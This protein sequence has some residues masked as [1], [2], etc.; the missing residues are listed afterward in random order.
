MRRCSTSPSTWVGHSAADCDRA[1]ESRPDD[2]R[3][4]DDARG[5]WLNRLDRWRGHQVLR[6][7]LDPVGEQ[8]ESHQED[9]V[10]HIVESEDRAFAVA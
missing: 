6:G 10:Q 8:G 9:A 1:K 5:S 7:I 3:C 2:R 4:C